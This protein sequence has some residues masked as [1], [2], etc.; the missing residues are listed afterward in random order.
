[1]AL[2]SMFSWVKK[3]LKQPGGAQSFK[4][5]RLKRCFQLPALA[6]GTES[7]LFEVGIGDQ[8]S[9]SGGSRVGA[10]RVQR[11]LNGDRL[12]SFISEPYRSHQMVASWEHCGNLF[13]SQ[14]PGPS[15][16]CVLHVIYGGLWGSVCQAWEPINSPAFVFLSFVCLLTTAV[17]WD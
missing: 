11:H 2:V 6:A 5:S 14:Y 9:V 8:M 10:F 17:I 7:L 3:M 13:I 4:T 1:M 16:P 15:W 12:P